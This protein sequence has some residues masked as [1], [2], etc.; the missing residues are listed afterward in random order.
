MKA[1]IILFLVFI[2]LTVIGGPYLAS[3]GGADY[4]QITANVIIFASPILALIFGIR[5]STKSNF[6]MLVKSILIFLVIVAVI[7]AFIGAALQM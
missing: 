3:T 2:F 4:I 5:A 6:G 1:S 7:A